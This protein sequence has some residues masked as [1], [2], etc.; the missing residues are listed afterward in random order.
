MTRL[1]ASILVACGLWGFAATSHAAPVD[2]V[3]Q[4]AV[5]AAL[6]VPEATARL[7]ATSVRVPDGCRVSQGQVDRPLTSSGTLTMKLQGATRR[8]GVC[9]GWARVVVSVTAPVLV[10]TRVVR[11]GESLDAVTEVQ[12]RE[13]TPGLR[14][15]STQTGAVAARTLMAGQVLDVNAVRAER[16]HAG[17]QVKVVVRVGTLTVEQM[18][19]VV[20]CGPG[21]SCAVLPS[22]KHVEGNMQ[23]DRLVV[24]A[25]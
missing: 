16:A 22:G 12:W 17:G 25:P 10:T 6:T 15:A 9:E 21:R 4:E 8:G 13:L 24:M 3:V 20:S 18:G 7:V 5:A 14:P 19:R 11:P 2:V 23:N 1:G